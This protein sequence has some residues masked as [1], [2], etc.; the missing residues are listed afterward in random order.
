MDY[1]KIIEDNGFFLYKDENFNTIDMQMFFL[2]KKGNLEDAIFGLLIFYLDKTNKN[3][4]TELELNKKMC[5]LYSIEC[6]FSTLDVGSKSLFCFGFNM[7]SPNV[8]HDNYSNDAFEFVKEILYEPDFT[9]EKVFENVKRV[10]LS[11][12]ISSL[13]NQGLVAK[14]LYNQH[15]FND[16]NEIFRNATDEKYIKEIVNSITLKDLEK[17]YYETVNQKNYLRTLVFGNIN[18]E[19]FKNFRSKFDFKSNNYLIDYHKNITVNENNIE[20]PSDTASESNI[21]ITY[22]IDDIDEPAKKV[23]YE[24]LNGSGDLCFN[25]LREKYGLVYSSNAQ[26]S[27]S[28]RYI[29]IMAKIDKNNKQ[30]FI[31]AT[32]E[33]IETIKDKEKLK[34]LLISAKKAIKN[35]YYLISEDSELMRCNIDDFIG[36]SYGDFN[37]LEFVKN[38]DSYDVEDVLK[39]TKT[40]K[41]KNIFMYRGDLHE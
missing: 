38:I 19:E 4:K 5:E 16:E 20:I 18:E 14:G 3:Y 10:Y 25:I 30:K 9:N 21:F 32:E 6:G 13:N 15:V 35:T 7:V 29:V 31:D 28:C 37:D 36:H 33:I 26:I 27:Y 17:V 1:N 11:R 8:V 40:L 2:R 22:L 24:V 23:L 34:K 12:L 39:Y 41:R